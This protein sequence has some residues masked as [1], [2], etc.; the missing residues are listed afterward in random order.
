MY[1]D[2]ATTGRVFSKQLTLAVSSTLWIA[3]R[4]G[5]LL[6][7]GLLC[8]KHCII[9]TRTGNAEPARKACDRLT[10]FLPEEAE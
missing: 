8:W 9:A 3:Q 2:L 1:C 5:E 4:K 10:E 7:L 6:E